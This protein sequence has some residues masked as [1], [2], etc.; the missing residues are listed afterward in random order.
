MNNNKA[1]LLSCLLSGK[2]DKGNIN[3][4]ILIKI[5]YK[6]FILVL[7]KR[8]NIYKD[9]IL[10]IEKKYKLKYLYIPTEDIDVKYFQ[11]LPP[12]FRNI[13]IKKI[14]FPFLKSLKFELFSGTTRIFKT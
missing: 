3:L 4:Q 8:S 2:Y 10:F 6:A 12:I 13:S 1:N 11:T 9:L 5:G 14:L 7:K